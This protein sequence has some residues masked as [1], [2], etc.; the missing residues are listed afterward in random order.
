MLVKE[1]VQEITPSL[2]FQTSVTRILQE[3]TKSY[4]VGVMEDTNLCA[5]H[6]KH[7]TIIPKDM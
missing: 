1:I 6:T 3:A 5:I 4:I 7:V 2:R